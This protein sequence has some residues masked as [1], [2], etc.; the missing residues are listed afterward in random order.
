M[1]SRINPLK[2]HCNWSYDG[3]NAT[4]Q[5][6]LQS[7]YPDVFQKVQSAKDY[8]SQ[9]YQ[10]YDILVRCAS[11]PILGNVQIYE[12][13]NPDSEWIYEVVMLC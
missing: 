7:C 5:S 3:L 12:F 8:D 13:G 9:M 4:A 2:T 6:N 1:S 11:A 10:A